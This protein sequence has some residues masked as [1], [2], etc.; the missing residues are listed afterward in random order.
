MENKMGKR[1]REND[2]GNGKKEYIRFWKGKW[3]G[4]RGICKGENILK[5]KMKMLILN[6]YYYF[7]SYYN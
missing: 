7:N 5:G 2:M 6:N 4:S 3:E 1:K